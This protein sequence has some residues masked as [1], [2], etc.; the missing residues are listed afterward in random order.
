MN[1]PSPADGSTHM[2]P[3]GSAL[4]ALLVCLVALFLFLPTVGHELVYDDWFLIDPGQNASMQG[5]NDDFGVALRLFG[6]A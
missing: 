5:I 1:S 6:H 4:P 2:P 3:Q